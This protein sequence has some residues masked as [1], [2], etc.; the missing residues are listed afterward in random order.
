MQETDTATTEPVRFRCQECQRALKAEARKIGRRVRCP[1]CKTPAIVPT[2][3]QAALAAESSP[4]ENDEPSGEE[5]SQFVVYDQAPVVV[6]DSDTEAVAEAAMHEAIVAID[7]SMVTISRRVLYAQGVLLG[8][9]ALVAFVLGYLLGG[10]GKEN[11]SAVAVGPVQVAGK[12]TFE[13]SA[14]D[15]VAD[16]RAVIIMMPDENRPENGKKIAIK[17]LHPLATEPRDGDSVLDEIQMLGG[18]YGR[19]DAEGRFQLTVPRPGKYHLLVVSRGAV[20]SANKQPK[21]QHLAVLGRY[22]QSSYE[23]IDQQQYH[24]SIETLDKNTPSI[25]HHFARAGR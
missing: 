21:P 5:F 9:V 19:T 11:S 15:R 13:D 17:G 6:D 10:V 24:C 1:S 12:I 2:H 23:L 4:G 25:E 3:E 8:G 22:F 16:G 7:A 20:R 14:G 18:V